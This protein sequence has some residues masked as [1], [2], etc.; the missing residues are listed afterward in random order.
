MLVIISDLHLTDGSSGE[1]IKAG[2]FRVFRERLRDLAYDASWRSEDRY[3]P[4]SSL[5]VLLLGDICDLIRSARW[6]SAPAV[7]RPW[8]DVNDPRFA[9]IV[10]AITADIL[11]ANA[12]SLAVL[13]GLGDG[14]AI[15]I[16]PAGPDGKPAHVSRDPAAPERLPVRVNVHYVI[17]NH[18][19]FYCL[20]G[21]AFDAVRQSVVD[22]FRLCHSPS[23][24]FPH[25]PADADAVRETLNAHAVIARHGDVFDPLN[26]EG[27][28]NRSSL[29]DAIVIELLNRFPDEVV[30][31]MGNDLPPACLRGLRELDN[32]RPLLDAPGWLTDL[33]A[34]LCTSHQA[35]R[36]K[37]IWNGIVDDFLALPFVRRHNTAQYLGL[38]FGL[39]LTAGTSL[40]A[41]TGVSGLLQRLQLWRQDDYSSKALEDLQGNA[42]FVVYGH[43]HGPDVVGV[44]AAQ[45]AA[46]SRLYINSGTWRAVHTRVRDGSGEFTAYH[47]MTYAAFFK[48]GERKG[49][50]YE[51][52]TGTLESSAP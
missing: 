39:K 4:I 51:T 32:V 1:T 36:V 8:G 44:R 12:E 38:K 3:E 33:L 18:D 13:R 31:Q 23:Q 11:N 47:V 50:A 17:G 40:A 43:T 34:R 37:T 24:P 35:D 19:W 27:Q 49:R 48:D 45:P 14:R 28:R 7:V 2:A 15:S 10:S 16:P 22:A 42:R 29:G 26:F 21:P 30:K 52:W 9:Q 5:D 6:C 41:L 20:P 46:P 25:G